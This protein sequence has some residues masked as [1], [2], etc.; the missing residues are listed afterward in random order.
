MGNVKVRLLSSLAKVFPDKV[1]GDDVKSGS[2][3]QNERFSFQL[4][5]SLAET[6]G[7]YQK[8]PFTLQV[9]SPLQ[10]SICVC[11]VGNVPSQLPAFPD[12]AQKDGNYLRTKP[13][14][15]PDPLFPLESRKLHVS[16]GIW[17]SLWFEID[18][19]K[20]L[21]PGAYPV[22]VK[23]VGEDGGVLA[24]AVFDIEVVGACL[25]KQRLIYTQWFHADCI[26][27]YYRI[28]V[29]G[30]AHWGW[31]EKFIKTAARNGINMLL[32]PVFTPPL[33]TAVGG[34]RTTVQLVDVVKTEKGWCFGF[35]KLKRWIDMALAN[36]MEY[37]EI[38]HLFT[39][40][41]AA[42][43]PKIIAEVNGVPQR[44]FGWETD[45]LGTPYRL[46]LKAFLSALTGFLKENGYAHRCYFHVSDEP[47]ASHLETYQRNSE[48]IRAYTQGFPV[49]DALSNYAYYEQG[50]VPV[51]V[52]ETGV[53]AEFYAQGV[54]PLWCYYC[55][56]QGYLLANRFLSMPSARNRIIGQQ[57]YRY[58]VE[59]FLHWGYNF[60]N[61]QYSAYQINPFQET[62]AGEGFPSGD[63]FSVY[64]GETEVVESI[65]LRVFYEGLQDLRA[66]QL[67]E[68]KIGRAAV[69]SLLRAQGNLTFQEY[70]REESAVLKLRE[71]VNQLLKQ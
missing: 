20:P 17:H 23:L 27:D 15:F 43:A 24:E 48:L 51:P 59:G 40:W 1:Y 67:L 47:H 13:G 54:R 25:P 18:P 28:P 38:S 50:L 41:G 19:K 37:I 16:F 14:L 29:F 70:P 52:P 49:I 4:A 10:D 34:E 45:A 69:E 11:T 33:D 46:F 5:Y 55:C 62:D 44:V 8:I 30:E 31:I 42:H 6:A 53:A 21:A 63:A 57:M 2:M 58:E 35:E 71:T 68:Q 26:A 61:A 7:A 65:G 56:G 66:L 39:Q 9:D 60:Y 64:P 12:V 32:T 36:G 3:L 22:A